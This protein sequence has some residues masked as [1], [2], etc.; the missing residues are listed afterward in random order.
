M[1]DE[2]KQT[3]QDVCGEATIF[4]SITNCVCFCFSPFLKNIQEVEH[5]LTRTGCCKQAC[6]GQDIKNNTFH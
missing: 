6:K 5:H 1:R 3:P 4:D 2:Q